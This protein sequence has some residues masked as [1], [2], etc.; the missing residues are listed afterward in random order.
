MR[1]FGC[2]AGCVCKLIISELIRLI[3]QIDG[4][5]VLYVIRAFS[6]F[7]CFYLFIY[8]FFMLQLMTRPVR[9]D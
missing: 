8:L 9:L 3:R 1:L 6:I 7:L 5:I 2:L 4:L